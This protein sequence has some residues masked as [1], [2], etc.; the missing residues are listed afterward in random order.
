MLVEVFKYVKKSEYANAIVI[1][2]LYNV[3]CINI[4]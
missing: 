2:N 4:F 1:C 3:I